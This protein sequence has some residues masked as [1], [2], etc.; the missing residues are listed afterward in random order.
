MIDKI[1]DNKGINNEIRRFNINK[2]IEDIKRI[3]K[4][5]INSWK[6]ERLWISL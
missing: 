1:N 3:L 2:S 4:N 6:E 5:E